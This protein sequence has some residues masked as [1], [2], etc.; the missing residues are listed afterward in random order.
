HAAAQRLDRRRRLRHG[1]A[2]RLALSAEGAF[3]PEGRSADLI[4]PRRRRNTGRRADYRLESEPGFL[5]LLDSCRVLRE[6]QCDELGTELVQVAATGRFLG[7]LD[8]G[9]DRNDL[10]YARA[11]LNRVPV[12]LEYEPAR[13]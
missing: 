13:F 8:E 5:R 11:I 10:P 2:E 9:G 7:E 4:E 6:A 1:N 3:E 12:L